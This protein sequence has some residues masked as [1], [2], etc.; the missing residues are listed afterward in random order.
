MAGTLCGIQFGAASTETWDAENRR[1]GREHSATYVV[2]TASDSEREDTVFA[3]TGVP[4]IGGASPL[5]T[6]ATCKART[7]TEIGSMAWE[8]QCSFDD[9]VTTAG[10]SPD[11]GGGADGKPW[12]RKPTWAWTSENFEEPLWHDA[13]DK[14]KKFVNS[15]G[16]PLPPLMTHKGIAVLRINRKELRFNPKIIP[17]FT[18]KVNKNRFWGADTSEALLAS[19]EA[20]QEKVGPYT[21]WAVSYTI[22]F[23]YD[24]VGWIARVLDQGH[25]Y[26]KAGWATDL[27]PTK[28]PFG[29]D[30]F[31]Q[32]LGNLD[33]GGRRLNDPD[34][35]AGVGE[36]PHKHTGV[37]LK[38][39][40]FAS[41]DFQSLNL[42]PW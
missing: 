18:N 25:Q 38:F 3:T 7:A 40:R 8:V 28:Y 15:A 34:A 24:G 42:G 29:D 33:G 35:V 16:D 13:Q 12:D 22:K 2:Q 41:A 5:Y 39:N 19:I 20:T 26:Y 9:T 10:S 30:A 14:N 17:Q 31:Q 32:V 21:V 6:G 36:N 1:T 4:E 23:K 37:F 11:D 27:N